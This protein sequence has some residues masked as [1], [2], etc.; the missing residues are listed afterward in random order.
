MTILKFGGSNFLSL[1][2]YNRVARHL[3]QRRAAGELRG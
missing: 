3:A 2:G 1:E